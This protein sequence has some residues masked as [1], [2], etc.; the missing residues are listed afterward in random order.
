[1]ID[2]ILC[3][4]GAD[5]VRIAHDAARER[6]AGLRIVRRAA[7]LAEALAAARAGAG[8]AVLIDL[9]V[10][11]LD[12]EFLADLLASG[13]AV[14]GLTQ[15]DGESGATTL[16]LRHTVSSDAPIVRIGQVVSSA[17][18]P[19]DAPDDGAW[20]QTEP[21][22]P[23][24]R[25]RTVTVWGPVGAPGRTT[26]AANLAYEAALDGTA[27]VL[28]DADTHGPSLTQVF[29]V[30]DE[31]P[32]LLAACRAAARDTLDEDSLEALLPQLAPNLRLLGGIGVPRRWDELRPSSLE[33]VLT[34]L[35]A[36]EGLCV[37][38][39]GFG[40]EGEEDAW[41]S[42]AVS[43]DSAA[44]TALRAADTVL[45]VTS[46]DPIALTRLLRDADALVERASSARLQVV[47]NRMTPAVPADRVRGILARAFGEAPVHLL[48]E[49]TAACRRA[50][51]DG[52]ALAECAP[53]SPLRRALRT[54]VQDGGLT[55]VV[56]PESAAVPMAG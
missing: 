48:P 21:M 34:V 36:R 4:S 11:G 55:A 25:A 49:D 38:D 22:V 44:L 9:G 52:A 33:Q 10:R 39:A 16:G 40:L 37:L 41:D 50:A 53:R 8:Q 31:A 51:W 46:A 18:I 42:F 15:P 28:V 45:V 19:E 23:T 47:V 3:A 6:A 43:R 27:T 32:G 5:E 29:G 2:V 30:L 35:T 13:V 12:R 1:M 7:D 56:P 17:L 54:M 26:V 20:V 14:I 24:R